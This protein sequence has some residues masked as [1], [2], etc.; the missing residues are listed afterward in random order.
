MR[1]TYIDFTNDKY[2]PESAMDE[3]YCE[4]GHYDSLGKRVFLRLSHPEVR[5]AKA[6][7]DEKTLTTLAMRIFESESYTFGNGVLR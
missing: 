1:T 7:R 4:L 2:H 3:T 5:K 6:K